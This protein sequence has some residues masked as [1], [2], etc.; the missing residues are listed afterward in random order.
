MR[1]WTK[2]AKNDSSTEESTIKTMELNP[3]LGPKRVEVN[4]GLHFKPTLNSVNPKLGP[5]Y[6]D[7]WWILD[8]TLNLA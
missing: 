4:F 6:V 2:V 8:L 7:F 3:K 1:L 5:C